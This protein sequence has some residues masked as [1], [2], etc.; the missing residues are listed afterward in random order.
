MFQL[1]Y[2][3]TTDGTSV[4]QALYPKFEGALTG[5][6][7]YESAVT[8]LDAL[9]A[10]DT[11]SIFSNG[12]SDISRSFAAKPIFEPGLLSRSVICTVNESL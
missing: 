2:D 6:C 9:K 11:A 7:G 4:I 10:L 12:G 3:S 5:Q 1:Y 8:D